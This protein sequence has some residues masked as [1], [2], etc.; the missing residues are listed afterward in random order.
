[1]SNNTIQIRRSTVTA[2]PTTL[3]NGELA[4]SGVSNSLF[5]GLPDGSGVSP[6]IAGVKYGYLHSATPGTSTANAVLITDATGFLANLSITSINLGFDTI[7]SFSTN[8]S[9]G[10]SNNQIA[11]SY[12]VKKYVDDSVGSVSVN[13]AA[14]YTWTNSHTFEKTLTLGAGAVTATINATS[15]SG[16]AASALTANQATS[17]NNAAYL[18]GVAAANY[19]DT[20]N[21]M[22][23]Y[24][25]AGAVSF[26]G[27][28][29]VNNTITANGTAGSAGQVLK[30]AGATGV[31]WGNVDPTVAGS[32][33]QVQFNNSGVLAG[34]SSLTFD[35]TVGVLTVAGDNGHIRAGGNVNAASFSVGSNL[36]ANST[37]IVFQG[38]TVNASAADLSVLNA[39]IAGNLTVNGTTTTINTQ[40]LTVNDPLIKLANGNAGDVVDIGFYGVFDDEGANTF[41]GMFR[42]ATDGEF[43]LFT[44]LTTEPGT[45]VGSP[46]DVATLTAYLKSSALTTNSTAVAITAN[47]T[48]S[49]SITANTLTLGTPLAIGSG[50][51]GL[52][53]VGTDGQLLMSNGT[54]MY[55]GALDGGTF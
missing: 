9:S 37:A 26:V 5:I 39:T 6:A 28:I 45:T 49:V 27:G 47:S 48:V 22:A 44:N 24:T 35:S 31:Y 41:T 21:G 14:Q 7:N 34:S 19:L 25:V 18:G 46:Y 32:N 36:V 42:D 1:M 50:G 52:S 30:S 38:A 12:A 43:K 4:F 29:T 15:Y 40:T 10:V 20:S 3:A 11:S 51:T 17:A 33:T 8:I 53:T 13:T 54:A 2:T 55:W 16:E 23:S